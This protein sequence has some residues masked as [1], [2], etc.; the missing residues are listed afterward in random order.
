MVEKIQKAKAYYA[1]V[2]QAMQ[3]KWCKLDVIYQTIL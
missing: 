2:V 3:K 1:Q